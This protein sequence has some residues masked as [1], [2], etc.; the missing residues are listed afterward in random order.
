[1]SIS[2]TI[3]GVLLVSGTAVGA[4]MLAL[5][6]STGMAGYF[7]TALIFTFYWIY[8][9]FTALLF[10]EITLWMKDGANLV[11]MAKET[12]GNWGMLVCWF[13]YLFL[14]Y[15]LNLAYIAGSSP[16]FVDILDTLTGYSFPYWAGAIALLAVFGF[17]VYAGATFVD[18]TNRILMAGLIITYCLMTFGLSVYVETELL[19]H[20]DWSFAT[21]GISVIATSFGFHIIIPTLS[22]YLDRN[23]IQIKKVILIG[24]FI[25][26]IIYLIWELYALG[27]IPLDGYNGIVAGY[28]RGENAA[29]LLANIIGNSWISP[30]ARA[31]AFFAIVTSFLGVSLS[32]VDFLA[33][34]LNIQK[35]AQGKLGLYA[36][37]F[38]PP[39]ILALIDP[40]AFLTGLE[41]AGA[42]GVIFLL[43]FMPA[44]MVWKGRYQHY[45]P[46]LYKAPGNKIALLMTMACSLII[47]AIEVANKIGL[48]NPFGEP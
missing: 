6:V 37:A 42:F 27:I 23:I 17:C 18:Y 30:V 47:M 45:Y 44:L 26:F 43:G 32:L 14:L 28:Q 2:K 16:I 34:G 10:L 39:L 21:V 7:P 38:A 3:G 13:A 33:D 31:F 9:T 40:R 15:S 4:G 5:P 35:T 46:S 24:S 29:T 25:P 48:L 36:L 1:M 8:M 11:T 41:Y 12:L 22:T 20:I 19:Q